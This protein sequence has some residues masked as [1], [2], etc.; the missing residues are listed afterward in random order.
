[1]LKT[2][3]KRVMIRIGV[4]GCGR[5]AQ[6]RHLPT[7]ADIADAEL[8]A[9]CDADADTRHRLSQQ[10]GLQSSYEDYRDLVNDDAVDA[11]MIATPTQYHADIGVAALEGASM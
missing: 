2:R 11:V 3:G 4:I 6:Q 7:V 8:V 9:I 1:M 5:V 10:F